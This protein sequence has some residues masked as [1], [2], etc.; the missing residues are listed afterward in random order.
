[1]RISPFIY[2]GLGSTMHLATINE[3]TSPIPAIPAGIE[4][5]NTSGFR[6]PTVHTS[7]GGAAICASGLI[8]VN[9]TTTHNFKLPQS[10]I[11]ANQTLLTSSIL[12]VFVPGGAS[13]PT[14]PFD[15][16]SEDFTIGA[17]LCMPS[18]ATQHPPNT[19]EFLTHGTGFD[20]YYWD[21]APGYSYVDTA[22]ASNHAVFFYDRLGNG[23]SDHA[24]PLIVQAPLQL[25]LAHAMINMLR[26]DHKFKKVIGVG[27]SFG[28]ILTQGLNWAYPDLLDASVLTGYGVNTTTIATLGFDFGSNPTIASIA[29]SERFAGLSNGYTCSESVRGTQ[30]DYL[31]STPDSFDPAILAQA[32]AQRGLQSAGEMASA[33]VGGVAKNYTKPLFVING[34]QDFPFCL[35]NCSY[36]QDQAAAV[37]EAMYPAVKASGFGSYLVPN[38]G[39]G[40]NLHY[41]AQ[42]AYEVIQTF[43]S[44]H[45]F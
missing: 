39:H 37:R 24:D 36:P 2:A 22:I 16:I 25:E 10:L 7:G 23:L 18:N 42:Q 8:T 4:A 6:N 27:H 9:G 5:P 29:D 13:K 43:L 11:P 15:T 19:V 26:N 32:F 1:M 41:S 20:R 38:A 12:S 33:P 28:S 17:S 44:K 3:T 34:E 45:G 21:F 31:S 30:L 35:G 40:L 14:P